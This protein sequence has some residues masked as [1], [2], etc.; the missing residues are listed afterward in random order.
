M[1]TA[2]HIVTIGGIAREVEFFV[3]EG[4]QTSCSA[5][6]L[7]RKRGGKT[8]AGN[9]TLWL[10]KDGSLKLGT[11]GTFLNRSGYRLIGWSEAPTSRH[12]SAR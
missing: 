5:V 10:Q 7:F 3:F 8:W 12:N 4:K 1:K 9:L 11:N 2:T 6:G